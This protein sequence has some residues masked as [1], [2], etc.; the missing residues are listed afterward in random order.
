MDEADELAPLV[1]V[2]ITSYGRPDDVALTLRELRKQNYRALELLFIDDATPIPLERTVKEIWPEARYIRNEKNLGAVR[3]RCLGMREARGEFFVILDDDEHPI[4]PDDISNAISRITRE[5]SIGILQM[6]RHEGDVSSVPDIPRPPEQY[7]HTFTTGPSIYRRSMVDD[8]GVFFEPFEYYAEEPEYALRAW[9]RGWRIIR[10]SGAITHHRRSPAGRS[11]AR[12]W[13]HSFRNTIWTI[14]L[15]LPAGFAIRDLTWKIIV[16][17]IVMVRLRAFGWGAWVAKSL[18][19]SL[20][21]I[22]RNRNPVSRQTA[23]MIDLLRTQTV[24]HAS[25]LTGAKA[26]T[27]LELIRWRFRSPARYG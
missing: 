24:V 22:L 27:L 17:C 1:T 9:S 19:T 21:M 15:R 8:I 11:Q 6:L 26:A 2:V 4:H 12:I 13:A 3:S 16:Y 20:P 7:V 25:E 10:I 23:R 5:P 14:L 18:V